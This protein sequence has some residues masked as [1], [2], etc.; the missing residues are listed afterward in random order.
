MNIEIANRLVNLR[1]KNNLSQ[2][3]LA[4]K[5]GISRQAVS[6][7]E[8]AEAS[9]DTDNLIMLAKLYGISLDEMLSSE[10][11]PEPAPQEEQAEPEPEPEAGQTPKKTKVNI[12]FKDGIHVI[13]DDDEVHISL[14]GIN[15]AERFGDKVRVDGNRIYVNE[16]GCSKKK[17]CGKVLKGIPFTIIV[18]VAY[19]LIGF[20]ANL[21]Y[22]G[23]VVFLA[24][25]VYYS[26]SDS[27][28]NGYSLAKAMS[29]FPIAVV[30]TAAFFLMGFLA[31]LWHPGWLVFLFIPIYHSI[32]S[33]IA[34]SK[35]G[36]D[37]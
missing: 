32:M 9:P 27:I 30:C 12:S 1:K 11:P 2:E 31:D 29:H 24:I 36:E 20:L 23:W 34:H 18:V 21:W 5:L 14:G 25:P 7:W 19:L 10:D 28:N 15:V 22:L 13:D 4:A 35:D 26:I 33:A 16:K 3:E 37:E 17:V 8:R 6:K